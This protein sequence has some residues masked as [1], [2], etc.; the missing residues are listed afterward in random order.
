M[1]KRLL[2]RETVSISASVN[3]LDFARDIGLDWSR[4]DTIVGQIERLR[5]VD[6][7]NDAHQ[8]WIKLELETS[9]PDVANKRIESVL[10]KV[11][12][13]L[14]RYRKDSVTM[15]KRITHRDIVRAVDRLNDRRGKGPDDIGHL[16]Y[17]D[18]GGFGGAYRP[19]FYARMN[20]N[21]GLVNV[22]SLYRGAT[23][24]ETLAKVEKAS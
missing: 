17:A 15:T 21:G 4:L 5:Y 10:S 14:N 2:V 8:F 3:L 19:S 18:I 20:D 13:L 16:Q 23:L 1:T 9:S 22:A 11:E 24:R 7:V 6:D 12:R